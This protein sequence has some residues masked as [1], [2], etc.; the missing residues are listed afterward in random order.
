MDKGLNF[1]PTEKGSPPDPPMVIF[2]RMV[3]VS[4]VEMLKV[5]ST[6]ARLR[7][8]SNESQECCRD[9]TCD[10]E[11]VNMKSF[12][13]LKQPLKQLVYQF[14]CMIHQQNPRYDLF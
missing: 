2:T 11:G 9:E 7:K 12:Q 5:G 10:V 8:K 6:N 1:S 14:I 13:R 3:V 4:F